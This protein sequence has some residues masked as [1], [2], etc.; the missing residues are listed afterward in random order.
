MT[1]TQKTT[2]T[3]RKT[4]RRASAWGRDSKDVKSQ[5]TLIRIFVFALLLDYHFHSAWGQRHCDQRI[6][7]A[8]RAS[9]VQRQND[10]TLACVGAGAKGKC[11][12]VFTPIAR[13]SQTH[14]NAQAQPTLNTTE[15]T[16]RLHS[17]KCCSFDA[18]GCEAQSRISRFSFCT[19]RPIWMRSRPTVTETGQEAIGGGALVRVSGSGKGSSERQW[20]AGSIEIVILALARRAASA[21]LPPPLPSEH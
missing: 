17:N 11:T 7:T 21:R 6:D 4:T 20:R 3:N 1:V 16:S 2:V 14:M 15:L 8:R 13:F 9:G 18:W 10:D 19:P 5:V 12:S